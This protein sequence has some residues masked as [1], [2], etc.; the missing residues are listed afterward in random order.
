M[1]NKI[2][3]AD[4]LVEMRKFP[5]NYFDWVITDPPYGIKIGD[6]NF[7]KSGAVYASKGSASRR[8]D[9]TG[10]GD[11]DNLRLTKQYFD[12]MFRVSKN[13][14]IFGGN[15]YTDYLPP[16]ASWI[17]WDKRTDKRYNNDFADCE[18]M[19]VSSG[20]VARVI[21]YLWSGML[22]GDMKHKEERKHPTQ[23]PLRVM[24]EIVAMLTQE[25]QIVLDPFNGSGSTTLACN[26]LKRRY[27]GI[28]INPDYVKI[29]QN[30]LR[31]EM[32]L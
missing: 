6:M 27:I 1:T 32:L 16:T 19:W 3:L 20:G 30:R 15:Y 11:W 13:Q 21:R 5:D 10:H 29:A 4:C 26:N 22:Q 28:E 31:Q 23:K 14:A 9:Y 17:V 2:I 18:L 7:T 8:R 12:E 25:G 24:S